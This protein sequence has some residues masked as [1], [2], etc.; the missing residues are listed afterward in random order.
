MPPYRSSRSGVGK[1]SADEEAPDSTD[2]TGYRCRRTPSNKALQR[3]WSPQGHRH[4]IEAPAWRRPHRRTPG[5]ST[6]A[7]SRVR[8]RQSLMT[9]R[10]P[11]FLVVALG[12]WCACSSEEVRLQNLTIRAGVSWNDIPTSS[13]DAGEFV[14]VEILVE[15]LPPGASQ[16]C[17]LKD[18]TVTIGGLS[19]SQSKGC[20]T[21]QYLYIV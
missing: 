8:T 2:L 3:M 5:R 14:D 19:A 7:S 9:I 16:N 13:A 15:D 20:P 12:A 6:V 10:V 4:R 11:P 17:D 21:W 18:L 1:L